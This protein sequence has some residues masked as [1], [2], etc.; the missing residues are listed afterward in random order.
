MDGSDAAPA[1]ACTGCYGWRESCDH[2]NDVTSTLLAARA[3]LVDQKIAPEGATRAIAK[4]AAHQDATRKGVRELC[5]HKA[6]RSD[7]RDALLVGCS[8]VRGA[9]REATHAIDA[10]S[11]L[12]RGPV[13]LAEA[14]CGLPL[15]L[16]GDAR[17]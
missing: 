17:G 9:T 13:A 1:W 4:F 5:A 10:A 7:S 11:A 3:G 8:Y 14:C 2:R 16:A 12:V 15:L 6:A